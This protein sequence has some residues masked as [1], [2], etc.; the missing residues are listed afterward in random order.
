MCWGDKGSVV[1]GCDQLLRNLFDASPEPLLICKDDSFMECNQAAVEILG[2]NSKDELLKKHPLEISPKL[3][4]DGLLSIEKAQAN[5]SKALN[6]GFH[7]FEWEHLKA[8]GTTFSVVVTLLAV[9]REGDVFLYANWRENSK[10]QRSNHSLWDSETLF[11]ELFQLMPIGVISFEFLP[12]RNDFLI[13]NLN[14]AAEVILDKKNHEIKGSTFY[15]IL[16]V[17]SDEVEKLLL[18]MRQVWSDGVGRNFPIVHYEDHRI[19]SWLEIEFYKTPANELVATIQNNTDKEQNRIHLELYASVYQQSKQAILI[20]DKRNNIISVNHA[21]TELTGYSEAE[22]V[23]L[24]PN[25]LASGRVTKTTYEN[26]WASLNN[27]GYWQ[28]ELWDKTKDGKIYPKWITISTIRNS[29]G[30]ITYFIASFSDITDKKEAEQKIEQLSHHDRLTQLLNRFSFES[31]LGQAISIAKR[32]KLELAVLLIDLDHF[33][34]INTSLGHKVGDALLKMVAERLK[35]QVRES[36]IVARLGGDEFTLAMTDIP[37]HHLLAMKINAIQKVL[38]E[39]YQINGEVLFCTPSIGVSLYP[40]DADSVQDL[41]KHADAAMYHAKA[42][43]R[44]N[45]Q[46]YSSELA[47]YSS[48]RLLLAQELHTAIDKEEFELHYQPKIDALTMQMSGLE[49]LIRWRHPDRG[50]IP[51]VEFIPLLEDTGLIEDVGLW[52]INEVCRQLT[53][54]ERKGLPSLCTAI[55]LSARQLKSTQLISQIESALRTYNLKPSALELEITETVAMEDPE[56]A[57]TVLN[58]INALGI[59]IAIDDFGTGYSSLAYLKKLPIQ[60]LKLDRAFVQD[61]ETDSNDA[62]ISAATIALAHNLGLKVVAEGVETLE[63]QSFL[64]DH[65]CDMLQGFLH[66]RPEHPAELEKTLSRRLMLEKQ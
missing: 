52:V 59:N 3:Q 24:N 5:R 38:S 23:G 50:L 48:T 60:T 29:N 56:R 58:K 61:I 20:S 10:I 33:K 19:V 11:H 39:G 26:M 17:H 47:T 14:S 7:Q 2:Y 36:D 13:C 62:A 54:W 37:N 27:K 40:N 51:P 46:Y 31:R 34:D 32:H 63:Q 15:K 16:S 44:K 41:I 22:V 49:A 65:Q 18:V 64:V 8:D 53:E 4:P 25:L 12:N 55:N 6:E 9:R 42:Q 35:S 57:I 30:E 66:G 28:G 43:G 45:F 21:F 1:T